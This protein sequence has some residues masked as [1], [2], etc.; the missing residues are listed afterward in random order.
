M[1]FQIFH[2]Y[3]IDSGWGDPMDPSYVINISTATKMLTARLGIF[4]S[5]VFFFFF[6]K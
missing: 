1:F 3:G 5:F 2:G 4:P 6:N